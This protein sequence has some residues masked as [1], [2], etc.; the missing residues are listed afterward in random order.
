MGNVPYNNTVD[1]KV[2]NKSI[3]LEVSLG[4]DENK[5]YTMTAPDG[6]YNIEVTTKQ[7]DTIT[8]MSVL[9]GKQ[10]N[11]TESSG[12]SIDFLRS[13]AIWI[14]IIFV[15]GFCVFMFFKKGKKRKLLGF[16]MNRKDKP[17]KEK[18]E[19]HVELSSEGI[20]SPTGRNKA[21]LSLSIKGD[22]QTV[23]MAC[24]KIKNLT[25]F[26]RE[27]DVRDTINKVKNI[28]DEHKAVLYESQ[29]CLF[30]ILMPSRTRTSENESALIHMANDMKEVLANHNRLYKHKLDFG[31]SLN[32]GDIIAKQ[33]DTLKIMSLGTLITSA[34]KIA[35]LANGEI[36]LSDKMNERV[37][38]FAKTQRETRGD[39][40]VYSVT[41]VKDNEKY[42]KFLDTFTKRYEEENM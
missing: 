4:V 7:G 31:I 12:I 6:G 16:L 27:G 25:A 37:M 11:V 35:S 32:Y 24:L 1:V 20:V 18:K 41:G 13:P 26:G 2:G 14:F 28:A 17:R 39:L 30:F 3:P 23:S 22:K 5:K 38:K 36:L 34:K 42:K 8:G 9:T 15:L 19:R 29:D 33:E 10:I 21:E 40:K